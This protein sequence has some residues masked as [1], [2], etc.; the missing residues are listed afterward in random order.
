MCDGSLNLPYEFNSFTGISQK[1]NKYYDSCIST[2]VGPARPTYGILS[3]VVFFNNRG[4]D[5]P[6]RWVSRKK[7]VFKK[8]HLKKKGFSVSW[9]SHWNMPTDSKVLLVIRVSDMEP[10]FF[11]RKFFVWDM[12][13][14]CNAPRRN[15]PQRDMCGGCSR[16]L[17][18][19]G[20][21]LGVLPQE[22]FLQI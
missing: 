8:A 20:R 2:N 19:T 5:S 3:V 22:F 12:V 13:A 10:K 4:N 16:D 1:F 9:L 11:S 21:G 7:K 6:P 14:W 17:P 15:T 18:S